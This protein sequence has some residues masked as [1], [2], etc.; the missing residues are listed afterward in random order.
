MGQLPLEGPPACTGSRSPSKRQTAPAVDLSVAVSAVSHPCA[1][2]YWMI[3]SQ[4]QWV[5]PSGHEAPLTSMQ[6]RPEQQVASV[7]Q[8]SPIG[9]H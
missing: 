2:R 8:A 3:T 7:V 9:V 1:E 4:A 5:A 6:R